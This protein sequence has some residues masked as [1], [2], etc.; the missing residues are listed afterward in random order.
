[1]E[2]SGIGGGNSGYCCGMS[3][4]KQIPSKA[5]MLCTLTKDCD[6][7][8]LLDTIGCLT[9]RCR[10]WQPGVCRNFW[11]NTIV[12]FLSSSSS[13]AHGKWSRRS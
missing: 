2:T 5:V 10:W 1:V 12:F 6:A 3:P 11:S 7:F 4:G 8:L 13:F 9:E